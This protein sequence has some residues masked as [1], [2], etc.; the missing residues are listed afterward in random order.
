MPNGYVYKDKYLFHITHITN[1]PTIL[2]K[3][4]L[5]KNKAMTENIKYKDVAYDNIQK[6]RAQ[7][8]IPNTPYT[9]HDCVPL[10]FGARPPM[11]YTMIA[12]GIGQEEMVYVVVKWS[13]LKSDKTWFTD[14]NARTTGTNFYQGLENIENVDLEAADAHYW[15]SQGDEFRRKKQAEVLRLNCIGLSEIYGFIVHNEKVKNVV[16]KM[17]AAQNIKLEVIAVPRFY[18]Q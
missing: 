3:G 10:F 2:K 11:L 17:L 7:I 6:A 8:I 14:G 5:C 15:S 4:L 13:I 16:E 18:Y 9:L 12:R 1:I